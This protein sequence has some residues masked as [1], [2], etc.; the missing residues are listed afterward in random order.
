M[1]IGLC[2]LTIS[3]H[4]CLQLI[5]IKKQK[6][7]SILK[8]FIFRVEIGIDNKLTLYPLNIDDD[9]NKHKGMVATHA[10]YT[11]S[12]KLMHSNQQVTFVY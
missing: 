12:C 5:N 8:V 10:N 9:A 7:I 1:R 11:S 3:N 4:C 6:Q 2:I